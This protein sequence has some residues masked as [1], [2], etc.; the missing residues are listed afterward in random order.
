MDGILSLAERR[1]IAATFKAMTSGQNSFL[2][3]DR[4]LLLFLAS[5]DEGDFLHQRRNEL[6]HMVKCSPEHMDELL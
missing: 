2:L 4:V 3:I 5:L 1:T 6:A